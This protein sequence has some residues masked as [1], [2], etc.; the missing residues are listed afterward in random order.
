MLKNQRGTILIAVII[1]MMIFASLGAMMLSFFTTSTFSQFGGSRGMQAYYLAE[2]GYRYMASQYLNETSAAA[3][4]TLLESIH[5]KNYNLNSGGQFNLQVYPYWYVTTALPVG[6]NLEAKVYGGLPLEAGQYKSGSWIQIQGYLPVQIDSVILT[7]P[8]GITFVKNAGWLEA[9]PVGSTIYPVARAVTGAQTFTV[10]DPASFIPLQA[11]SGYDIFPKRNGMVTVKQTNNNPRLLTYDEVYV[12]AGTYQLRGIRDPKIATTQ[13]VTISGD[14]PLGHPVILAKAIRL[15]ST[16]ILS[17]GSTIESKRVVTYLVPIGYTGSLA[18]TPEFK[19]DWSNLDRDWLTAVGPT[20]P[21]S[22]QG[23]QVRAEVPVEGGYALQM[24]TAY[25]SN[26]ET[27]YDQYLDTYGNIRCCGRPYADDDCSVSIFESSLGL[28]WSAAGVGFNDEWQRAGYFLS[29]DVQV[30]M[31]IDPTGFPGGMYDE[32]SAGLLFRV[33]REGNA[34]G[35]SYSHADIDAALLGS[36]LGDCDGIPRFMPNADK[37]YTPTLTLWRKQYNARHAFTLNDTTH[38]RYTDRAAPTYYC[39]NS[40]PVT[41]PV[42]DPFQGGNILSPPIDPLS[43]SYVPESA[44][45]HS[46]A[47]VIPYSVNPLNDGYRV[48]FQSTGTLPAPLQ[49]D[50]DYYVRYAYYVDQPIPVADDHYYLVFDTEAHAIKKVQG[51]PP[52]NCWEGLVKITDAGSGTH[53]LIALGKVDSSDP[54]TP[55]LNPPFWQ[56]IA[57]KYTRDPTTYT[58]DYLHL[59]PRTS[60]SDD[61][62]RKWIT[63]LARVK[64]APS[65][66]FTNGVSRISVGDIVYQGPAASPTAIARVSREPVYQYPTTFKTWNGTA[67]GALILDVIKNADGTIK[68]YTFAAGNLYVVRTGTQLATVVA[69]PSSAKANWVQAFVAD[70]D[71]QTQTPVLWAANTIAWDPKFEATVD[72]KTYRKAVPRGS[73]YWPPGDV[74]L[75]NVTQVTTDNDYF[76]LV[77]WTVTEAYPTSG[78][79]YTV[80]FWSETNITASRPDMLRIQEVASTAVPLPLLTPNSGTFPTDRPEVGLDAYGHQTMGKVYFDD[81]AV[82]MQTTQQ[83]PRSFVQSFQ[84]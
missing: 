63:V 6:T 77:K 27:T 17:E 11:G 40:T 2:S 51:S 83:P 37:R 55:T 35:L 69:D 41:D 7:P 13:S 18:T 54:V 36:E 1:T 10:N 62:T 44:G 70:P 56:T 12:D 3:R 79:K 42:G 15:R 29:Y 50:T 25:T 61:R 46:M 20:R 34:Y 82:R 26:P 32:Y 22:H 67:K 75:D 78:T 47:I 84:Y 28:N 14:D 59:S 64:E 80:G 52:T 72:Y 4:Q 9:Y 38:G 39:C 60:S 45:R 57:R 81:F 58:N 71:D 53:T 21:L 48:R 73:L 76:T 16:G 66:T 65:I 68:P 5:N 19:A 33:D 23:T 43:T 8:G 24:A 74:T 49:P 31:Y 30:K